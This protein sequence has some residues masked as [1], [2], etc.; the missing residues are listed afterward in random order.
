MTAHLDIASHQ[1]LA[2]QLCHAEVVC[3][4]E[5]RLREVR[6]DKFRCGEREDD[7]GGPS[8]LMAAFGMTR[9]EAHER[10]VQIA[11]ED[12]ARIVDEMVDRRCRIMDGASE[13][14]G[15]AVRQERA[16]DGRGWKRTQQPTPWQCCGGYFA[17]E[18]NL[19]LHQARNEHE[20]NQRKGAA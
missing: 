7:F 5:D 8:M 2:L 11:V 9:A 20:R 16:P 4:L 18:R 6:W 15:A 13:A 3:A 12:T 14:V 1:R 17:S 10:F 19:R